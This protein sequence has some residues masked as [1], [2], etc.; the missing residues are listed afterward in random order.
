[1]C[2]PFFGI[3]C[4]LGKGTYQPSRFSPPVRFKL[5]DGWGVTT[6]QPTLL[7][8]NRD[9]GVLTLASA[10]SAVYPSG[11]AATAPSSARSLVETFIETD[12]VASGKPA[13][14]R[15]DKRKATSVDLA[16]TGPDRVALF[17]TGDQTFYLEP[18]GTTRIIVVDGKDGVLVI[19]IE[20]V[21]DSTLESLLPAAKAVVASLRFQ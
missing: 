15:V 7:A 14:T 4:A 18:Y 20:P 3:P 19:G 6:S 8:L 12:G 10:I 5:G 17:G 1:V 21:E 9:E 2:E 16:P 13:A 11:V